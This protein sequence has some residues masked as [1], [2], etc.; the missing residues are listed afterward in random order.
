MKKILFSFLFLSLPLAVCSSP[1]LGQSQEDHLLLTLDQAYALALKN[2]EGITIA[3]KEIVKSKL[4][5]SKA[6]S[7]MMP[8][9]NLY[10]EYSRYDDPIDFQV[11]LGGILLPP[12]TTRPE[13]QST[14]NF[15][16]IQP[17]YQG[18]WMP[19]RK[20]ADHIVTKSEKDYGWNAQN[21]LFQVAT[22]YY[23]I[24]KNKNFILITEQFLQ[25]SQEENRIAKIKF[26]EGAVTENVVL[27]TELKISSA[28]TRLLA[29]K[30]NLRLAQKSL[31]LLVGDIPD[32]FDI[33]EP[34]ELK[35]KSG[36][37]EELMSM[38][39]QDRMDYRSAQSSI[40]AARYDMQANRA[41]YQP[42]VEGSWN[43]YAVKN[44]AYDQADNYW[45]AALRLNIPLYDGGLRSCDLE[46]STQSL[47]Q[48]QLNATRLEKQIK[49]DIEKTMMTIQTNQSI[50]E[51][52]AKQLET[53]KK[54]YDIVFAK[55]KHGA[56]DTVELNAALDSLD[57]AN[58][59]LITSKYDQQVALLEQEKFTGIFAHD[60]V[61][62]K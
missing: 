29:E 52:L 41:R 16:L 44:P 60:I 19:R 39:R 38:A 53:A 8:H 32:E 43:Y 13:E 35:L 1:C 54:N 14:I 2:H 24:I 11:D 3:E 25:R 23:E 40:E 17:L 58:R 36:N 55:F 47:E 6:N 12:I 10:G 5:P 21:I 28:R 34:N 33:E 20:Q 31:S 9:L 4:L 57:K 51:S 56:V 42:S 18:T 37:F 61:S 62:K 45:I 49:N 50:L 15:N 7:L 26:M 22:I 27:S 46:A 30:N 48:A 59:D